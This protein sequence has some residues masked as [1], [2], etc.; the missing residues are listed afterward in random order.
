MKQ[1]IFGQLI[2]FANELLRMIDEGQTASIIDV[3]DNIEQG[4]ITEF[5][6]THCG[7]KNLNVTLESISEVNNVMQNKNVS[8]REAHNC[9]IDNNGLVFL[10]HLILEDLSKLLY[11]MKFNNIDPELYRLRR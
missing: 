10:V 8:E 5:I 11:D 2:R 7:F 9:G 4:T 1:P 6:R 3:C